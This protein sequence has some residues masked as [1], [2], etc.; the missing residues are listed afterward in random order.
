VRLAVPLRDSHRGRK[1]CHELKE[2]RTQL[3]Q[4]KNELEEFLCSIERET[5][6]LRKS[7]ADLEREYSQIQDSRDDLSN[8]NERLVNDY[9]E[10]REAAFDLTSNRGIDVAGSFAAKL[11][12]V[13]LP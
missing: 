9:E 4:E 3:A 1:E 13:V 10:L 12:D 6:S 2:T 5:A 11:F 7:P 8:V